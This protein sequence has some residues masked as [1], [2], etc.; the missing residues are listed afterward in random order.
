MQKSYSINQ[1]ARQCVQ[2]TLLIGLFVLSSFMVTVVDATSKTNSIITM[3][4]QEPITGEWTA[5]IKSDKTD[6]IQLSFNRRTSKGNM[7][8]SGSGFKFN[9]LEGLTREQTQEARADV[10]FR[11]VREA[12]T[13]ELIGTFRN[14][15]GAGHFTLIPNQS[16]LSAMQSRGFNLTEEQKF[17]AAMLDVRTKA[18]DDLKGAGYNLKSID[19][20]FEATIFKVTPEFISEMR[21]LGYQ[22]LDMEELVKARI[23]KIDAQFAREVQE[24]SFGRQPMESL[25]KMRIFKI[26]PEFLSEMRSVGFEKL[27]IEDLVKFK[28]FKIDADFIQRARANGNT[29]LDPEELVRMKIHGIVR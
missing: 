17:A 7:N 9:A 16:F 8:M 6:E 25:V 27:G 21:S 20:V 3:T 11:I 26:T 4:A 2:I 14:G 5:N 18:I 22:N 28:I 19:D 23:F 10:T 13:F 15:R 12:G 29:N 1:S 24:M